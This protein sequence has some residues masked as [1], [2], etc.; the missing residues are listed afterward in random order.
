MDLVQ[1]YSRHE[2]LRVRSARLLRS[3]GCAVMADQAVV[4]LGNF[5]TAMFLGRVLP[6]SAYGSFGM[7]LE[8]M[9]LLN[10]LH[11]ALVVYPYS[12]RTGLDP[13]RSR[14]LATASVLLTLAMLPVLGGGIIAVAW[15][16]GAKHLAVWAV[17]ALL[18]WQ[19]QETFRRGLMAELRFHGVIWGDAVSYLG[20]AAVLLVLWWAGQLSLGTAVAT[21]ALTSVAGAVIQAIQIGPRRVRAADV[22]ELARE[23]W[24]L[25]R[26]IMLT[27]A[28]TLVSE[29]SLLWTLRFGHGLEQLALFIAVHAMMK[30]AHPVM[31]SVTSLIIPVAARVRRAGEVAD[32][33]RALLRCSSLGLVLVPVFAFMLLLPAASLRLMYGHDTPYAVGGDILRLYVFVYALLFA[34]ATISAIL[35]G[36]ER[37]RDAFEAQVVHTLTVLTVATPLTF[38]FGVPGLVAGALLAGGGL[39]GVHAYLLNRALRPAG[40]AAN[41]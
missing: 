21:I 37:P 41:A 40:F 6:P 8:N 36:L 17:A 7:L 9:L 29:A 27:N 10:S 12:V 11:A 18:C 34:N 13:A 3:G 30:P 20:Q 16:A 28:L 33:R 19:V 39:L 31:R 35:A 24:G 4:S 22:K 2:G 32:G 5:A 15:L 38:L 23:F 14:Q 1:T 25:G 26:W